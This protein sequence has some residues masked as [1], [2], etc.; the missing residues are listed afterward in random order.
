VAL[1]MTGEL[2]LVGQDEVDGTTLTH[3]RGSVNHLRAIL[4]NQRRVFTAAGITSFGTECTTALTPTVF[5]ETG[6]LVESAPDTPAE[7]EQR[8][9]EQTF[10]EALENQEP[11]LSFYDENPATID[12]WVSADGFLIHR[13][14]LSIPPDQAGA[15]EGAVVVEYSLFN[16]VQIE[17]PQ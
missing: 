3:L 1:E 15:V 6:E 7:S 16:Q 12:I 9:R 17:A 4:E 2:E 5:D 13:V 10:E 11:G 14:A 8:C